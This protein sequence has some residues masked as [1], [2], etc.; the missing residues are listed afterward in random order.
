MRPTNLLRSTAVV[1]AAAAASRVLGFVRDVLVAALLGAGPVA[2][3]FIV[4]FRIPG[5]IRRVFAE[6]AL[7]AGFVPVAQRVRS[8]RGEEA[9]ARFAGEALATVG[10][11]LLVVLAL[12][13]LGAGLL[14]L[15]LASGYAGDP[16][17]FDLATLYT[18]LMLPLVP[19]TILAALVSAILNAQD[20]FV[21]AAVAP[22]AVNAVLIV[23]LFVLAVAS[24]APQVQAA[25]LAAAVSAGGVVQLAVLVPA[26]RRLPVPP[27]PSWPRLGP[28]LRRMLALSL[29]GV[30]VMAAAQ[31]ATVAA[32]QVASQSPAAVARLYY[33]DRLFQLPL[34]F[35]ASAAGVVLLP[36]LARLQGEGLRDEARAAQ[37]RAL[38]LAFLLSVPAAAG[39]WILSE[40]IV[41]VLFQR[42]AFGPADTADTAAALRWLAVGLPAAAV[43]RVLSQ[44]FFARETIRWPLAA[45]LAG[46]VAAW[47]SAAVLAPAHGTGGIAAGI[48][49]GAWLQAGLV[50]LAAG[51]TRLWA[52]DRR[53]AGRL[54]RQLL[55]TAVMVFAVMMVRAE[56]GDWLDP[57]GLAITRAA[58][59]AGL[60]GS[61]IAAFVAAGYLLGVVTLDDFSRR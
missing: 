61:G 52:P 50:A 2:D 7:H 51:A 39:L 28:D 19:A 41:A 3:A 38:E 29:P 21:L 15:G 48:S 17:L 27:I 58:A 43:S 12:G 35:V 34:G 32:T 36:L 56:W 55:A 26:L 31:L 47:G 45:A 46:V 25:V 1:S 40:P 53:L 57:A 54:L 59:L 8:E 14:V 42:G 23:V 4:A 18:R 60:C 11:C 9:S 13:E 10:L 44:G 33:A 49:I 20:R 30:A 22:A 24:P 5:L 37:N 6:G 16:A